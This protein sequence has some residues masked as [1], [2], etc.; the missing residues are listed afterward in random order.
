MGERREL[1]PEADLQ[2]VVEDRETVLVAFHA[3]WCAPCA[4]LDEFVDEVIDDLDALVVKVD[5]EAHEDLVEA[6]DVTT[7]PTFL[8]YEDGEVVER[9]AGLPDREEFRDLLA[10]WR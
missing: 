8:V 4:V 2:S 5:V 3:D 9:Q 1:A 10:P 7:N 6:H